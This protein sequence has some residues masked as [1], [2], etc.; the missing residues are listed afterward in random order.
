MKIR[1]SREKVTPGTVRYAAD[2]DD[3]PVRTIYVNKSH[4]LAKADH[5]TVEIAAGE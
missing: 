2:D 1:F 4:E 3:A 5:F